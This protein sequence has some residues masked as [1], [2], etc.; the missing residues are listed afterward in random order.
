MYIA[1]K[2][3]KNVNLQTKFISQHSQLGRETN[4]ASIKNKSIISF[5]RLVIRGSHQL[6]DEVFEKTVERMSTRLN[7][8]LAPMSPAVHNAPRECLRKIAYKQ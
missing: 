5:V 4:C 3:D 6:D 2:M 1:I 7:G 8:F